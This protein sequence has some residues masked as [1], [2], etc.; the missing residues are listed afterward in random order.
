ML[1]EDYLKMEA[2][3]KIRTILSKVGLI[4][5]IVGISLVILNWF[6][7]YINSKMTA[8][9]SMICIT[10]LIIVLF[11]IINNDLKKKK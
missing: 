11:S 4:I 3:M 2:N 1:L 9:A 10:S 7:G 8:G 6:T 5:C